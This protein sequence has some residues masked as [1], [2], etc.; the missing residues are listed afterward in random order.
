M[1]ITESFIKT[2]YVS[3]YPWCVCVYREIDKQI[4]I[5]IIDILEK[6]VLAIVNFLVFTTTTTTTTPTTIII[7]TI[8]IIKSTDSEIRPCFIIIIK[9]TDS[10]I[11]RCINPGLAT[12]Q[13]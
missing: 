9:S 6:R 10:E 5:D 11:R 12:S 3:P 7:I 4:Y 13:W 2:K 8:I 1:E